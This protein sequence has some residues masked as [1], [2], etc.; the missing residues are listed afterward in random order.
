MIHW[1]PASKPRRMA[2]PGVEFR[3]PVDGALVWGEQ[4]QGDQATGLTPRESPRETA[5]SGA[6]TE[7]GN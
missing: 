1:F 4:K 5:G 3:R 7:P 6:G 2:K